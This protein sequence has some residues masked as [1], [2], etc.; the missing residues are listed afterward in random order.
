MKYFSGKYAKYFPDTE[1]VA[2]SV[3]LILTL[4]GSGLTYGWTT[5]LCLTDK[6]YI[7]MAV[8]V[9]GVVCAGE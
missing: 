2:Y 6:L 8:L 4:V 7:Q 1:E 5:L 3:S 9:I